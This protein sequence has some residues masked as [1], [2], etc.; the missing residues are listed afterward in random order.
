MDMM[1]D[2]SLDT[3]TVLLMVEPMDKMKDEIL[4]G[5]MDIQWVDCLDDLL[6]D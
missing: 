5:L 6:A 4:V 1:M 2:T 3:P